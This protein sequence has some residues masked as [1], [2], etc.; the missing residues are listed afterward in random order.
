MMNRPEMAGRTPY[1]G[2]PYYCTF[3]GV[4]FAE[5]F[6]CEDVRCTLETKSIAVARMDAHHYGVRIEEYKQSKTG[7]AKLVTKTDDTAERIR[8]LMAE[9]LQMVTDEPYLGL[10]LVL[11]RHDGQPFVST[12]G[13]GNRVQLLGAVTDLQYTIARDGDK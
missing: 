9:L 6:A 5:Y 11:L 13:F 2:E 1:D 7:V 12:V 10:A 8:S 4:G 3:C